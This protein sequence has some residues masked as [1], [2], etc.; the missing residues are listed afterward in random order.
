MGGNEFPGR[1]GSD[2]MPVQSRHVG[3]K[4]TPETN[5]SVTSPDAP[6][7]QRTINGIPLDSS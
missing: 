7:G 4:S 1:D 6:P 2:D 5:A 3:K